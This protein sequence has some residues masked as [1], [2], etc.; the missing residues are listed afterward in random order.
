MQQTITLEDVTRAWHARDPSL[1]SLLVQLCAIRQTQADRRRLKGT[2]YWQQVRA[3]HLQRAF[4]SLDGESQRVQRL[5]DYAALEAE[6]APNPLPDGL[7]AFRVLLGLWEENSAWARDQLL[8]ALPHL[9]LAWGPWRGIKRIFKE[10]EARQDWE[11]YGAIA[12]RIDVEFSKPR[13]QGEVRRATLRY[14]V[15]RA[16]R[17]LGRLGIELPALYPDAASAVLARYPEGVRFRGTWIANHI[18]FHELDGAYN[19]NRFVR[20]AYRG[21]QPSLGHQAYEAAWQRSPRPLF[22][23]LETAGADPVRSFAIES[24]KK[25]FRT[26]LR[27][28]EVRWVR[29]L[30][31]VRAALVHG[32]VVWLLDNVPRFEPAAFR[33]LGLHEPVL[34]L[35]ESDS[36]EAAGWA[37]NYARTHAR[38]L[39]SGRLIHLANRPDESVREL[40][41]DLLR[42][43]DPRAE[44]GLDAWGSL[45]GTRFG[46]T[47]ATE[48]IREHFGASELSLAWFTE[49]LLSEDRRVVTF[50]RQLRPLVHPEEQ[51][52]D[53]FY[54]ELLDHPRLGRHGLEV[55]V[56]ALDRR[57]PASIDGDVLRRALLRPLS[58][59]VVL[60]WVGQGRV[61]P[62]AFGVD[63]VKAVAYPPTFEASPFISELKRS[64]RAWAHELSFD[65]VTSGMA[66]QWL[67]DAR[68]FRAAEIGRTWLLDMVRRTEAQWH[69]FA[70][71]VLTR[72]FAPA[73]L[74]PNDA[75]ESDALAG[76]E[77]LWSIVVGEGAE[78]EPIRAF[79]LHYLRLHH[80]DIHQEETGQ[81]LDDAMQLPSG[82]VTFERASVLVSDERA[83]V[84]E[85]GLAW[86][87][88]DLA[89]WSPPLESLLSLSELPYEEVTAFVRLALTAEDKQEHRRYRLDPE[90]L[91]PDSVYRMCDSLHAPTRALGME[92]ISR[93]ARLAVPEE[94][95]RL[96]ESP[97]RQVRAFVVRQLWARYRA[98]LQTADWAPPPHAGTDEAPSRPERWPAPAEDL[99]AFL[100]RTLFGIPPSRL[101]KGGTTV[102][103]AKIPARKAKLA[104]IEVCRDL[105]I[106]DREFAVRVRPLF[107]EF[108]DSQGQAES[109][110]CLV[111]LA[112]IAHRWGSV[113]AE[114]G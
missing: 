71:D 47:L 4:R 52:A 90:R 18:F 70:V 74:D 81:L 111:A 69:D 37:A 104:L 85:L 103:L 43:R 79:A 105:A 34:S 17:Q 73:D 68:A 80:P 31:E 58:R 39:P 66:L 32:F 97:D 8:Q 100:R 53:G 61:P 9:P 49:R 96:T 13:L 64:P 76:S 28:V 3:K 24:L 112:R 26:K 22:T 94:L 102:G 11:V 82:F 25:D 98:D 40:A 88:T 77:W 59:D 41:R 21:T 72:Q 106:E 78:D 33:T 19:R 95:F 50:A 75:S 20:T 30:I 86:L 109:A 15:R 87:R 101:P 57:D 113:Q 44:V 7:L 93:H 91:T 56:S 54:V 60:Q 14:L 29:R 67:A 12:A 84:R 55:V 46:H 38:D 23:L 35:L 42:D 63:L 45:L 6:E 2:L 27:D 92:L 5:A 114:N 16:W 51:V 110:A 107:T 10:A 1:A 89:G 48:M 83:G 99:R 65:E 108:L 36:P 62:T